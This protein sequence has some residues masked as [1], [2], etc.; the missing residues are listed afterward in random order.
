MLTPSAAQDRA[1]ALIDLARQAGA[2]AAD[3]I[4]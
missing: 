4:Y 3:A 2:D 1:A